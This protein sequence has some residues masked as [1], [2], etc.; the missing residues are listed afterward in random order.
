[1]VLAQVIEEPLSQPETIIAAE[2]PNMPEWQDAKAGNDLAC[3]VMS[4][5]VDELRITE[6]SS[7]IETKV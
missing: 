5:P 7:S 1:M 6:A 4:P 3:P 2:V